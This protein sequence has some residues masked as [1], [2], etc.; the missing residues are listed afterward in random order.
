VRLTRR[1]SGDYQGACA[2]LAP[3]KWRLAVEDDSASWE[4]RGEAGDRIEN[5]TLRAHDPGATR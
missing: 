4:V 2:P 1:V 3:G 5:L